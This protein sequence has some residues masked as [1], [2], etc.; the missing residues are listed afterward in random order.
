MEQVSVYAY[1]GVHIVPEMKDGQ[2]V[3]LDV[4]LPV[5]IDI[6]NVNLNVNLDVSVKKAT[7]EPSNKGLVF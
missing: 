2:H 4:S 6:E 3:K 7:F 1:I 5:I